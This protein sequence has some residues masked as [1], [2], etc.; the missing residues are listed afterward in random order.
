MNET[1]VDVVLRPFL[2]IAILIFAVYPLMWMA[3]WLIPAGKLKDELFRK[4]DLIAE[5]QAQTEALEERLRQQRE[6]KQR[7]PSQEGRQ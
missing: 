7:G 3:W 1:A 5:S 4:R 2:Y 6:T